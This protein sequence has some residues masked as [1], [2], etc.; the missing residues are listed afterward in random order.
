MI[1]RQHR[2]EL[3]AQ[4]PNEHR[5]GR[6]RARCLQLT[7]CG[8][9]D[10]LFLIAEQSRLPGVRVQCTD[11][12]ARGLNT[13]PVAERRLNHSSGSHH[14]IHRQERRYIAER[15]VGCD[16]HDPQRVG[17]GIST[18]CLR[19]EHHR[20]VD[21]T[22]QVSQPFGVARIGKPGEMQCVFVGG[23]GDNSVH[24]AIK[25]ELN[26]RLYR[27]AGNA[28]GAYGSIAIGWDV[29]GTQTPGA[30]G[31]SAGGGQRTDLILGS[32]QNDLRLEGSGQCPAGYL[33]AYP[34]GI[35]QSNGKTRSVAFPLRLLRPFRP[36]YDLI[37]T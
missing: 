3:T 25:R 36:R 21:V 11:R 24:L 28:A 8:T 7:G 19:G 15:Y 33:R 26:G 34:P 32:N 35:S 30:Y 6:Q 37:S 27:V 12:K 1:G 4:C 17:A 31:D 14:P 2:I 22:G 23:R 9:E 18:V 29:S 10:P 5:V 20:H 13:P 16:Q